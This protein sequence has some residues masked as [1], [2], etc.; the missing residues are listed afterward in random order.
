MAWCVLAPTQTS[1]QAV[2]GSIFGT[3][4]DQ[5]GATVIG[6]KLTVTSLQKG[7]E[8]ETTT[9][10]TGNYTVTHLIPDQYDV[11]VEAPGFKALHYE[12]IPVYADQAVR[13][14]AQLQVG[15][16][17]ETVS[18]SA[19][20]IPLVKTDR[21]DVATTF[22][23]I[24]VE[25]LPLLDRNFTSLELL[26]PGAIK[27]PWQHAQAE[28]PQGG[29]QIMV[30]GQHFSGT[31]YQLDGTDNR[32]PLLGLIVINP[33][34]ESVT[35]AKVTTQN[36]DAEFGQ[37]LAGVVTVQTKSGTNNFHGSA[38]EYRR[39][40][41][42]QARNPFTQPPDR[43]LPPIKWNQFGG[44]IGGP[45][46]SN[47]LFFFS[48]YQ[49]TRRSNGTSLRLNVPTALARSTCL[50]P[51]VPFCDLSE[52]PEALF[53]PTTGNQFT[54]NQIPRN[55]ISSQAVN[56]LNLLPGPNVPG[57][58]ITQ[59]FIASGAAKFNDD[60]FNVRMDFNASERLK[61]FGRYSFG[62]FREE[63]VGAFGSIA[64]GPGLSPDSFAGQSLSRNQSIAAGFDYVLRPNLFTD[65][66][67]GFFR[68]HIDLLPNGIGTTP[69]RSAG[70]RAS[71]GG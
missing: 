36:Y 43:P 61:I 47:R 10:E 26:T 18:V 52:Y 42:G 64:G 7:T 44:S 20:D 41:W 60:D 56:L 6:G 22:S 65:F 3:I 69:A 11:R 63:A 68:Y 55:R 54:M 23:Q 12:D 67:F 57:A 17:Q 9:N 15:G 29:I 38:F 24:E 34:L 49:G 28:N 37:A 51:S 2:Y 13:V 1:A 5:S 46:V 45:I 53:D 31:S 40:G 4:T 27:L 30:N 48:D 50:D 66:R 62:D 8:S 25:L 59:N 33:T 70:I 16:A 71:A 19:E 32:D 21:A 39:T 35:Q 14:D 58:G